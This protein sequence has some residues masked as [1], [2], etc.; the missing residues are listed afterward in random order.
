MRPA[1]AYIILAVFAAVMV[2]GAYHVYCNDCGS[3]EA[4]AELNADGTISYTVSGPA[5][6]YTYSVFSGTNLPEKVFLYC[7]DTY[8]SD[9]S[10]HYVQREFLQV[11]KS[12]LERREMTA[13]FANAEDLVDIMEHYDYAVFFA[14][15]ALPDTV[16][17]GMTDGDSPFVRW[18]SNGGTVYWTGPE[19]G[20]YV[21]TRDGVVDHGTGFFG[22]DVNV[23]G[24][25]LAHRESEMFLYTQLRYDDCLYGLRADRTDSLPLSFISD[26]GYSSVSVAKVLGGNV[27]VFGGNVATTEMV[28]QVVTDRTCCADTLI[29]GLTYES[30]GLDHGRGVVKG[31]TSA[32][33]GT[34]V[35]GNEGTMFRIIV[36]DP[37]S[38]WSKAMGIPN[39]SGEVGMNAAVH[40]KA[41]QSDGIRDIRS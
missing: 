4:F 39:A 41:V 16:Y 38:H 7:D 3:Y 18:M 29:C 35:S 33:T 31:N 22:G 40:G 6:T 2:F 24:G 37:A 13:K 28:T 23:S 21:S 20:R 19:I 12:M 17:D 26:D 1:P 11:L 30:K 14:S 34:D 32:T 10:G 5:S 25:K 15:G 9:F 36:G 27:T 8:M